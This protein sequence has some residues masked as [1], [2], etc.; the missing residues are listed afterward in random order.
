MMA[1]K[2][3]KEREVL[4]RIAG[5]LRRKGHS[6]RQIARNMGVHRSTV[7]RLLAED[8][9]AKEPKPTAIKQRPSKLDP[10]RKRI[11]S[12]SEEN[13]TNR[14]ILEILRAEGYQGGK[15]ILGDLLR[16]LRGS[17]KTRKAFARYEPAPGLEAQ[18]DWS[19]WTVS[20]DGKKTKI[21]IFSLILS[22]SRYMYLEAFLDEK[23]DTLF[24]G[25]IEAFEYFGGVPAVILYDNQTAVVAGRLSGNIPVLQNR[26]QTFAEHYGFR[27]KLCL[28]YDKERKGRVERVFGYLDTN[29][30]PWKTFSSLKDLRRQLRY[31]LENEEGK[32]GNYRMHGT[33]RRRPVDM[34]QEEVDLLIQMPET[35][36]LP[37]RVEERLV[38]K[39]CLIS[40]LGNF[41]TVPPRYVGKKVTV[42]ISPKGISVFDKKR[43][44]VARHQMPEGKG[45]MVIDQSH[46]AQIRRCKKYVPAS[47][48]EGLFAHKFP[49]Q[50]EFL[51]GLKKRMK[52][53]YPIHLQRIWSLREHFTTEQIAEA[54]RDATG[55]GICNSTYVEEILKRRW[56]SQIGLRR[57]DEK[58][59]KPKG[60]ELGAVEPGETDGFDGIFEEENRDE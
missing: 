58:M 18:T 48:L 60:L 45:K 26:F 30:F 55:H 59:S 16:Q 56:P 53:I 7:R 15:S 37:T 39:D 57:F 24:Q 9:S 20:I 5:E 34:W 54:M 25:H 33:T 14:K 13:L 32:T 46:Y 21:H 12:L 1:R 40:V 31:W 35:H 23:Q 22:Y 43:E 42:V 29:F 38:G 10:Y 47:D 6:L 4:S 17:R 44:L 50:A 41:F 2:T 51:D 3:R 49:E 52:S 8:P 28:P 11:E 27:P 19:T 36:L